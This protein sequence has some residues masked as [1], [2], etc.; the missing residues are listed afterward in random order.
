MV[1]GI[2]TGGDTRGNK[3]KDARCYR[4]ASMGVGRGGRPFPEFYSLSKMEDKTIS[5]E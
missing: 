2:N 3:V 1:S 5:R 4:F